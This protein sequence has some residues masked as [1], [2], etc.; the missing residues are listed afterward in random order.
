MLPVRFAKPVH[1]DLAA[2]L[3]HEKRFST[4]SHTLSAGDCGGAGTL[5]VRCGT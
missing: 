4:T 3:E 2:S 5:H 1:T